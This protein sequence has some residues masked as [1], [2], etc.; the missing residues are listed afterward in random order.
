[1]YM[2]HKRLFYSAE[3]SLLREL[4]EI[5]K[6]PVRTNEERKKARRAETEAYLYHALTCSMFFWIN[7]IIICI[8]IW[9][10]QRYRVTIATLIFILI[11]IWDWLVP[12]LKPSD[13]TL[14]AE[15]NTILN[16]VILPCCENFYG[17]KLTP[18]IFTYTGQ[19]TFKE[20]GYYFALPKT[21]TNRTQALSLQRKIE[22]RYADLKGINEA[23]I[24]R[25]G[26]V[27]TD[28]SVVFIRR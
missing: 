6:L 12:R 14:W 2:N 9:I 11:M 1:M 3:I 20:T 28:G 22:R 10:F 17:E 5:R 26:C 25:S 24:I 23:D 4:A 7:I 21:V 15:R 27:Y 16:F 13:E 18:E 8:L 19:Q